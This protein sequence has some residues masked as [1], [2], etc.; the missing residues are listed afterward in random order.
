MDVNGKALNLNA[1]TIAGDIAAALRAKKL[2]LMT[3]V[4]GVLK[5]RS[6]KSSRISRVTLDGVDQLIREGIISGGMI[7]KM[8]GA[9]TAVE[10]GVENVHIIDGS[11]SHSVLLELFTDSGIGTMV[12]KN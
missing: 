1:D 7:P 8:K 4:P 9:A 5:D 6:D 12:C 11:V 2:I 3:D 10:S